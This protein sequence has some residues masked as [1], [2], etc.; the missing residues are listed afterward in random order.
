MRQ[1]GYRK[2]AVVESSHLPSLH[3]APLAAPLKHVPPI[4]ATQDNIHPA[5]STTSPLHPQNPPNRPATLKSKRRRSLAG[6]ATSGGPCAAGGKDRV[7]ACKQRSQIGFVLQFR[8]RAQTAPFRN[9][10]GP[11]AGAP[12]GRDWLRSAISAED[13]FGFV[14][15]PR[16]RR[17]SR[18]RAAAPELASFRQKPRRAHSP[19]CAS[20][21]PGLPGRWRRSVPRSFQ[22]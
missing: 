16:P 7:H 2:P 22:T 18:G 12:P 4:H 14:L 1:P 3:P 19:A 9:R 20:S 15:Q 6:S 21:R 17:S 10:A 5:F 11:A 8:P 13:Q